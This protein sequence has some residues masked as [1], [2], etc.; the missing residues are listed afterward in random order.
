MKQVP[1][2]DMRLGEGGRQQQGRQGEGDGGEGL[3]LLGGGGQQHR[4]G[5]GIFSP[6]TPPRP[7]QAAGVVGAG[8]YGSTGAL[9]RLLPSSSSSSPPIGNGQGG[10]GTHQQQQA[11][12]TPRARTGSSASAGDLRRVG[13]GGMSTP[14]EDEDRYHR[15]RSTTPT[16]RSSPAATDTKKKSF[17]PASPVALPWAGPADPHRHRRRPGGALTPSPPS[18]ASVSTGEEQGQ[19]QRRRPRSHSADYTRGLLAGRRRSSLDGFDGVDDDTE[20]GEGGGWGD[21][22]EAR[23]EEEEAARIQGLFDT[24]SSAPAAGPHTIITGCGGAC[25]RS[26]AR[27]PALRHTL[28]HVHAGFWGAYTAVRAPLMVAIKRAL[29]VK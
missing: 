26:L 16:R 22:E 25:R 10:G 6:G 4:G 28:P 9:D 14:E 15:H 20:E 1:L 12:T 7:A 5:G 23:A 8:R 24:A 11:P 29:D 3:S 2:P 18:S 21:E 17:V 19:G 13:I 27:L